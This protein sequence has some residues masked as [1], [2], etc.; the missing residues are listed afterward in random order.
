MAPAAF[1]ISRGLIH[2]CIGVSNIMFEN[3]ILTMAKTDWNYAETIFGWSGPSP[4][5][6]FAE[7][8]FP[9]IEEYNKYVEYNKLVET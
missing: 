7:V 4:K 2:N 8:H 9:R 5:R 6:T 3:F 1:K